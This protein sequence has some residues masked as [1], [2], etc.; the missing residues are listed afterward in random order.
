MN[1]KY[2][3]LRS[4]P[5]SSLGMQPW[6][7]QLPVQCGFR[8]AGASGNL[9]PKLE[10]GNQRSNGFTLVEMTVVLLLITLL[11]SVAVR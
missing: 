7:L 1:K 6:K 3:L 9:V 11:A 4:F 10:L 2:F 8:E 5:S